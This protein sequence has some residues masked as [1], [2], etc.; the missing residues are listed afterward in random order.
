MAQASLVAD[1]LRAAHPDFTVEIREYVT[2]G[3]RQTD[4]SLEAEGGKGLFTREIEEALLR[5]EADI[6]VHSAKDLPSAEPEGLVIA[7][8]LP[9]EQ[10]HDVLV[11]RQGLTQPKVIAS[12]SPRRRSQLKALFSKAVWTELR[13]NVETR[14]KKI[15]RGDADATVLAAAGL[16]RLGISQFEGLAF[17]PLGVREV[18]PAAGQGA[19]ALQTRVGEANVIGAI[20]HRRTEDAVRLERLLL[21]GLGGGCHTATAAHVVGKTLLVFHDQT[22]F[23]EFNLNGE[24]PPPS[25]R[26]PGICAKLLAETEGA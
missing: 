20:N 12:G 19:I 17:Q 14:L 2:T 3:D 7:G 25:E 5:G 15:A 26:I 18:V 8:F 16:A 10:A 23:R 22:G 21:G 11:I 9:R 1:A 6:A 24:G 13:G 4:W